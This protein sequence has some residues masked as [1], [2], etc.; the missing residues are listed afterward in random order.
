MKADIMM[1]LMEAG[2]SW[3]TDGSA[4]RLAA[5]TLAW[6]ETRSQDRSSS[7]LGGAA[8]IIPGL[9]SPRKD[10]PGLLGRLQLHRWDTLPTSEILQ[11]LG[12]PQGYELL[13]ETQ[14]VASAGV[15]HGHA[16]LLA[17]LGCG[18]ASHQGHKAPCRRT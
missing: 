18:P 10:L 16:R 7:M 3:I 13:L 11:R 1:P 4:L 5:A 17:Q 12:R 15:V 6:I 9:G 2:V 14:Q 8:P